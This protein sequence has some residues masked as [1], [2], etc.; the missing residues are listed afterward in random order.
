VGGRLRGRVRSVFLAGTGAAL[1]CVS[2]AVDYTNAGVAE[3]QARGRD[4][5]LMVDAFIDSKDY[6]VI[7]EGAILYAPSLWKSIETINFVGAAIDPRPSADPR[8]ENFWTFYFTHRG[9]KRVSVADR[10]ERIPPAAQAQG[11]YYLRQAQPP[12]ERGQYLVFAHVRMAPEVPHF[13]A[14]EL[15]MVYDR[16]PWSSRV[17]GGRVAEGRGPA[18]VR[19]VGGA[20]S[21]PSDTFLFEVGTHYLDMGQVQRSAVTAEGAV[22]DAESVFLAATAPMEKR[23][24]LLKTEGWFPDGWI[25]GEARAMLRPPG[26]SRLVVEAYA[27]DY[28]FRKA[29]IAAVEITMELDGIPIAARALT[30]GGRFRIEGNVPEAGGR[31]L[32]RCGPVHSPQ[33]AGVASQDDRNLCVVIERAALRPRQPGD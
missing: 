22:I 10:P 13:L 14:S 30:R 27:P 9:G 26:P 23:E 6:D 25:G 5:F 4:R 2:L 20:A 33:A 1:V 29:G 19:L 12:H 15:V 7:P 21:G 17:L 18:A 3:L 24:E 16:S 28:I 31:L 32:I 11:F 8:Y